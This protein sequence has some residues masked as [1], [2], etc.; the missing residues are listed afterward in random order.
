M[1]TRRQTTFAGRYRGGFTLIELIVVMAIV[2]LLVSIAAPRYFHSVARA[3]ENTL[4][5][6]LNVMR[7]AIDHFAADKS[8]YPEALEE[9]VAKRY[10]RAIPDD[11]LT[12]SAGTWVTLTPPSDLG[13]AGK[14]YDVRSGS[15]S[16]A[17]DGR[18]FADW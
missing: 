13:A 4:R 7:D 9:L 16:R 1:L 8:R 2:A 3:R 11:P 5:T 6:S 14:V 17:S 12:G 18:L 10:L 15:A